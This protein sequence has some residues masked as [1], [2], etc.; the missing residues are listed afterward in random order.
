MTP[1]DEIQDPAEEHRTVELSREQR[2]WVNAAA[3]ALEQH[4]DRDEDPHAM[5]EA[6][7]ELRDL[8]A[9]WD[10]VQPPPHHESEAPPA[11]GV[12][13]SLGPVFRPPR[14]W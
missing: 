7:R 14:E 13:T 4:A 5:Y 8:V 3:A 11:D 9:D 12:G 10:R 1:L 2:D 6:A